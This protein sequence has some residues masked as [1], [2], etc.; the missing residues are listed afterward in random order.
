[1]RFNQSPA[2]RAVVNLG[3][4]QAM[5]SNQPNSNRDVDVIHIVASTVPPLYVL[6][7]ICTG[8]WAFVGVFVLVCLPVASVYFYFLRA[9]NEQEHSDCDSEECTF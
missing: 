7:R 2:Y 9:G 1:M 4:R 3:V 6:F 5:D 8:G